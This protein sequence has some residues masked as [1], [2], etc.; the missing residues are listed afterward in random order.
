MTSVRPMEQAVR[1]QADRVGYV[2]RPDRRRTGRT[3]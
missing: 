1:R 2:K 3:R